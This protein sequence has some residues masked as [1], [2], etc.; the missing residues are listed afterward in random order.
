MSTLRFK[1]G[2]LAIFAMSRYSS[3]AKYAGQVITIE[4]VGPFKAGDR[5]PMGPRLVHDAD[6]FVTAANGAKGAVK[7]WQLVKLGDPDPT[8]VIT[9]CEELS[10]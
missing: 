1:V 9:Q 8:D 4:A 5:H 2:E 6:Y 10:A 3:G 7:D